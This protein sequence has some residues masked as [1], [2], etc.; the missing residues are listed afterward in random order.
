M[1]EQAQLL[2]LPVM[3]A[4]YDGGRERTLDAFRNLL[5]LSGW[6][7]DR[8]VEGPP[9]MCVIEESRER[10]AVGAEVRPG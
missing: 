3:M 10:C 8:M 9:G 6:Q 1:T 2:A 4:L 7:L 5:H